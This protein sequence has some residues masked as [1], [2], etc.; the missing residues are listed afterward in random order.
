MLT[1]CVKNSG[2]KSGKEN[3]Y[4][5]ISDVFSVESS[6]AGNIMFSSNI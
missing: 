3:N 4:S 6:P 5:L 2:N 1:V